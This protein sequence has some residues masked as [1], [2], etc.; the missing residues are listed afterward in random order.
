M[1]RDRVARSVIVGILVPMLLGVTQPPKS[2]NQSQK[3]EAT[4]PADDNSIR[5]AEKDLGCRD[6]QDKRDSDLCAQWKAADSASDAASYAFW[7]LLVS[8]VGTALLV[9][10]LWETRETSRRELRAYLRVEPF[11]EGIVQPDKK[12]CWPFHII[13]YGATPAI[14]CAIESSIVVR[15]PDW[16]WSNDPAPGKYGEKRPSIT[17]H[18]DSPALIKLE[19]SEHLPRAGFEAVMQGRAVIFGRGLIHYKD[20]FGRRRHTSFQ[21]EFHGADAGKNGVGGHIRIAANGN[22]FS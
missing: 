6:R 10:T 4:T 22:D 16:D 5:S 13:N 21:V 11:G 9:W 2:D 20:V 8:A 18:P 1:I 12:V 15:P 7:T 17:I 14:A 3:L 19:M